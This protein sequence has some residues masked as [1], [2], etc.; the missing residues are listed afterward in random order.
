MNR[1]NQQGTPTEA[2]IAWLAGIVEGEGTV[3]LSC[4]IRSERQST[5]KVGVEIK[6]YNTD[7]GI[8]R[9]AT[10]ILE[11]L[12]LSFHLGERAQP[13]MMMASG[14]KY[15]GRDPMLTLTVKRMESAYLL[16]KLL[17]PWMFGDK[18]A[19]L[20]LIVQYL[21]RR[22]EK[23]D[24]VGGML[25]GR[26]VPLDREDTRLVVDFYRRFVTRPGHNRHLVE[27]LLNEYE[28]SAPEAA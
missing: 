5:P 27:G 2:E 8:I 10:D 11:R 26:R 19:R 9:K 15:G 12:G 22:I 6:L 1:E 21:A 14:E 23:F 28:Q 13:P 17:R 25:I 24:M 16:A 7:A 18:G 4:Y 3:A 20:D